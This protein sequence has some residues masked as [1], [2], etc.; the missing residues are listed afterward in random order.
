[1]IRKL[2]EFYSYLFQEEEG[3]TAAYFQ[4][5]TGTEYRVYFYPIPEYFERLS[6]DTQ[7]YNFGYFFGFTK[8]APNEGK[9]E[10]LDFRVRN[11]ILVVINDFFQ[12]KGIDKVLIFN[13]D[14]GDGKKSKRSICFDLWYEMSETKT[15]FKK[16]DEE[17]VITDA[18]GVRVDTDYMSLIIECNNPNVEPLLTEF[19]CL[20]E[21]LIA[22][23]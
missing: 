11:T 4:T 7:L 13:C 17:I 3:I 10:P 21:Q 6:P 12:E 1:M 9:K 15:C 18:N 16:Y 19:Q 2:T 8:L 23:K 22:N 20:K 14:D 5:I